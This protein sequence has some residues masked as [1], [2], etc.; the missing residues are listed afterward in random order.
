MTKQDRRFKRTQKAIYTSFVT[1]FLEKDFIEI[2]INEISQLADINRSTFYLHF[3]DKYALL[4]DYLL[5]LLPIIETNGTA[6][7]SQVQL[8]QQLGQMYDYLQD[9]L[10]FFKRLFNETNYPFAIRSIKKVLKEFFY[11]N[12]SFFT[13]Q[14]GNSREFTT[15][16]RIAG[17]IA[18]IEWFLSQ[19]NYGRNQFIKETQDL[20]NLLDGV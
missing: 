17:L 7:S 13:E 16:I 1:L 3:E 9:N 14:V 19:E 4:D 6:L 20:V 10:A 5:S 12:D 8:R 18:M 11:Q 15:H 2:T